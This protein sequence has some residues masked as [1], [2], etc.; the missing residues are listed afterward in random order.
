[1][2]RQPAALLGAGDGHCAGQPPQG[3]NALL[4]RPPGALRY[5]F[6]PG[7][8]ERHCEQA[9]QLGMAWHVHRSTRLG[10]DV[11][12]PSDIDDLEAHLAMETAD[13]EEKTVVLDDRDAAFLAS[14][15]C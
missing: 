8:F 1:M 4:V 11:D 13:V 15:A 7:S 10:L 9:R 2:A 6:G 14:P 5:Q 3:T 12:L